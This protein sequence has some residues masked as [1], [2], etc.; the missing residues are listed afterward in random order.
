[1]DLGYTTK[2]HFQTDAM[3][4]AAKLN[5][6]EVTKG[7]ADIGGNGVNNDTTDNVDAVADEAAG[8]VGAGREL[9]RSGG[10]RRGRGRDGGR[11]WDY[12]MGPLT[13]CSP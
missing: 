10:G 13:R 8:G 6:A 11:C 7:V 4:T 9:G 2:D 3:I 5:G 1:M 12:R